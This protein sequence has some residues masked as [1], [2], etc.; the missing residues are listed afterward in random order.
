MDTQN[1]A[2]GAFSIALA[3]QVGVSESQ[4]RVCCLFHAAIKAVAPAGVVGN[5][6]TKSC[7]PRRRKRMPI[8]CCVTR[9]GY[10]HMVPMT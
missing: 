1:L 5:S 4:L 8:M 9:A 2:Q 7:S 10:L 3:A 6:R